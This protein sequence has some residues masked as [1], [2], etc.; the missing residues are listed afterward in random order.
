MMLDE[1]EQMLTETIIPF[2]KN[3]R[4]R[5]A[6]GY[7]GWMDFHLNINQKAVKGCIL[8]SRILWFFS[9]AALQL[10]RD[11]LREEASHAYQFLKDAFWDREN[12][13]VYWSVHSDGTVCDSSKHTYNQAFAIYALSAYYELTHDPEALKL[14]LSIYRLIESRCADDFGYLEAFDRTFHPVPNEKLSEHGLNAEKTMNTLLHVFEGYSGLYRASREPDVGESMRRILDLFLR[15]VYNPE[16]QRQEVFFDKKMNSISDLYSYGHDIETSWLL[17]W[18]CGLLNDPE[19]S[20]RISEIT[21]KLARQVYLTAYHKHSLWNEC[22]QGVND[23][24]RI[25]WV[26]AESVIGFLNAY[27]KSPGHSEYLRAAADI[28]SYIKTNVADPRPGSEWFSELDD[29][30]RPDPSKPIV[31]PWKC[32]YHNGRMCLEVLRRNLDAEC[33][34]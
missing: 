6:G 16:K 13:G 7:Y 24:T 23:K 33:E 5:E 21:M 19:L 17:D 1:V 22:S 34:I 18:G 11:D 26:Q 20:R 30:G 15:K 28:W 3:M 32:P 9:T 27:Q 2:W 14:A 12:G 4:D 29:D 8:N 10:K 25:W 31:E